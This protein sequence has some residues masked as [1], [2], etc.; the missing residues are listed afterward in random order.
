M[1]LWFS[2]ENAAYLHIFMG[3]IICKKWG[4]SVCDPDMLV[5]YQREVKRNQSTFGFL[6]VLFSGVDCIRMRVTLSV[7]WL[8]TA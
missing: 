5:G 3:M 1:N 8:H 2:V 4:G 6:Y 7:F